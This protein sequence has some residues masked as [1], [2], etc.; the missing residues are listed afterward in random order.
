MVLPAPENRLAELRTAA[1]LTQSALAQ[2]VG[3][4][5]VTVWRWEKGRMKISD[6][7]KRKLCALL[8]CTV[9]HLL[10]WDRP[11]SDAA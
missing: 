8:G 6:V 9:E 4:D 7:S 2:R 1:D 11:E 10:G 3:V 5:T